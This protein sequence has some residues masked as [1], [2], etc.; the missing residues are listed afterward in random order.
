LPRLL[1]E[2]L[3]LYM[4]P[5]VAAATVIILCITMLLLLLAAILA[6]RNDARSVGGAP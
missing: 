5:L 1:W 3:N 2:Q 4:T 6:R